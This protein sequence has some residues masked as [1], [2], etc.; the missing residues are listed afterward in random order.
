MA[1][2][3]VETKLMDFKLEQIQDFTPTPMTLATVMYYSGINPY[4]MKKVPVAR[5][6]NEKLGQRKFFFWY[7]NEYRN[8]IMSELRKS[9]RDDLIHKLF[10][11][12][13]KSK[14]KKRPKKKR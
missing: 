11:V 10:G 4:T 1:E 8:E 2:L 6:K 7:K 5:S 13:A 3:A 14:K 12:T 9:N